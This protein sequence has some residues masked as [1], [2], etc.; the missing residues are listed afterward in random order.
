[1]DPIE[2]GRVCKTLAAAL[3]GETDAGALRQLAWVLRAV[4]GG[5]WTWLRPG[6]SADRPHGPR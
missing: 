1:M 6:G 4:A 2:A 3:G 5:A